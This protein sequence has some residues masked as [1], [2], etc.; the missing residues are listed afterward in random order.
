MSREKNTQ[1]ATWG[2][3]SVQYN[4]ILIAVN[5][6][7]QFLRTTKFALAKIIQTGEHADVA[8]LNSGV[9][10]AE[11]F[12]KKLT[13][14]SVKLGTPIK[15][16]LI[17]NKEILTVPIM[18][19]EMM[20]FIKHQSNI[21]TFSVAVEQIANSAKSELNE[22]LIIINNVMVKGGEEFNKN[23]NSKN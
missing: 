13:D 6:L 9:A 7:D 22:Y 15:D 16:M 14:D 20:S 21:S 3:I 12:I 8:K 17:K 10:V 2:Q 4:N 23:A 19:E 18:G 5:E 1:N 11:K